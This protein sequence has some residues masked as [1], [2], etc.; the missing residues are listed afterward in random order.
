MEKFVYIL[1]TLSIKWWCISIP[2]KGV[3]DLKIIL[4]P[5]KLNMCNYSYYLDKTLNSLLLSFYKEFKM[6]SCS[7][8][9]HQ[10][11]FFL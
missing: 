3:S 11:K 6:K 7:F 2:H 1:I 8:S 9:I 4:A 10:N 5:N